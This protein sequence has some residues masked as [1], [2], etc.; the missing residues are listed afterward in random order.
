MAERRSLVRTRGV[1]R[2]PDAALLTC[3]DCH[4]TA[5]DVRVE[6]DGYVRCFAGIGCRGKAELARRLTR[7]AA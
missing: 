7:G 1:V 2:A 4:R 3:A 6:G 5:L